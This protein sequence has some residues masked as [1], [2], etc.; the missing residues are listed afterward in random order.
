MVIGSND[1]ISFDLITNPLGSFNDWDINDNI[2]CDDPALASIFGVYHDLNPLGLPPKSDIDFVL[3]GT[4]P[5][6][7]MYV[8]FP[9]LSYLLVL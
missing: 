4:A 9:N 3:S 2:P 1:I 7:F 8:S 5:N 6:R